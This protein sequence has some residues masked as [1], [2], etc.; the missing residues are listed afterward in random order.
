MI[1]KR[2]MYTIFNKKHPVMQQ[3]DRLSFRSM[4]FTISKYLKIDGVYGV[5]LLF[6]L[7]IMLFL[8]ILHYISNGI[9]LKR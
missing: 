5:T 2:A 7:F 9:A 6:T 4:C 3:S 8:C 1:D